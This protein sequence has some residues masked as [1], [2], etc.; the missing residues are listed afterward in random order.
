MRKSA[1]KHYFA[2]AGFCGVS[3]ERNQKDEFSFSDTRNSWT[4]MQTSSHVDSNIVSD[5]D[6]VV[7]ED[8]VAIEYNLADE[9]ILKAIGYNQGVE[10]DG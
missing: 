8:I 10:I 7:N 9:N 4:T 1:I 6:L 5:D 2:K 3:E